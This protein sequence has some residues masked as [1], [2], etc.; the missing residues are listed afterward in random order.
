MK[1]TLL[2]L[3]LSAV[4]IAPLAAQS[5]ADFKHMVENY[6]QTWSLMD[7]DKSAAMYVKNPDAVFFDVTPMK[8]KGWDEYAAGVK[9]AFAN[10][11]SAKFTA[12]DDITVTRHGDWAWTTDTFHGV[13]TG[14]DGKT[15]PLDGRHTAI[16]EK[17]NGKWLIVHDHVSVPM[18]E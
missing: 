5:D 13:L 7:T 15:S 3:I 8:Y 2:A 9:K 16:W 17:I 6:W 18:A 11:A 1:T 12:N 10:T 4:C 14:K